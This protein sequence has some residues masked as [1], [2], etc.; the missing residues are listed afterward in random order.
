MMLRII[1]DVWQSSPRTNIYEQTYV[2]V[3]GV[4]VGVHVLGVRTR[5]ASLDT[6]LRIFFVHSLC[7][8]V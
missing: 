6:Y 2:Q 3:L 7:I 8:S 4:Q 1:L 5:G